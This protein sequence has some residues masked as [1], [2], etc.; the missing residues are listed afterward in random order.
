MERV[1]AVY[2]VEPDYAERFAD[3]ANQKEKVPFTAVAF[4]TIEKLKEYAKAHPIELLLISAAVPAQMVQ[5]LG[6]GRVVTLADGEVVPLPDTYQSVY[7]YQA[8]DSIIREV[9]A[10]YCQ[11]TVEDAY[12]PM[13]AKSKILGVYSCLGRCLKTS[14]ALTLGAQMA[15]DGKVLFISLEE[16]SGFSELIHADC[17]G[18]LSDLFYF[19]RQGDCSFTRLSSMIYTWGNLDYIPPVKYPEDLGQVTGEEIAELLRKLA[20]ESGYEAIIV[21]VGNLGRQ[22]IPIIEACDIIYM[23]VKEDCV[24]VAKLEEFDSYLEVAGKSFLQDRIRKLKLPYHSSFGRRD[25]YIEQLMWGE[26][27]DYVRQLLRGK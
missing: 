17:Q 21:D 19:Y 24:S 5:T 12:M 10:Y 9:L 23:P 3:F 13:G 6:A 11:Q 1:M 20:R 2:D 7:K 8:T 14:F 25:G 18:D 27:G 15:K 22:A 16:F 26:L 4:S